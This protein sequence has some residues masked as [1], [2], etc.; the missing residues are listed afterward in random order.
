MK[1]IKEFSHNVFVYFNTERSYEFFCYEG[2]GKVI[3]HVIPGTKEIGN[4][5][6]SGISCSICPFS[7]Y[8]NDTTNCIQ[9]ATLIF[10]KLITKITKTKEL[11]A[12]PNT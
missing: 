12:R 11:H 10:K 5:G 4:I 2:Q 6:C 9:R 8:L 1:L 3:A 7:N